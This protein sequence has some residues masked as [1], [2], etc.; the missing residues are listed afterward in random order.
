M[1]EVAF[2][3]R[4]LRGTRKVSFQDVGVYEDD[5]SM[6]SIIGRARWSLSAIITYTA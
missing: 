6:K 2:R 4:I 5:D 3:E 1:I